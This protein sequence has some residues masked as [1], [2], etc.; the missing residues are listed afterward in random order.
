MENSLTKDVTMPIQHVETQPI[1]HHGTCPSCQKMT[2]FNLL[3]VQLWPESIAKA[4]GVPVEQTVWQC[5][6]CDTTLMENSISKN[7]VVPPLYMETQPILHHGTCPCCRKKTYFD[8]LGI[9]LWLDSVS[10][11]AE[12]PEEQTVWKCRNCQTTL[13]EQALTDESP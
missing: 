13:M 8:L 7:M 11:T 6:N 1:L 10:E 12:M 9:Q 2:D 5:R 4:A 3:G